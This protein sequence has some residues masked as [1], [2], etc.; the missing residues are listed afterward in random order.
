[1]STC[2]IDQKKFAYYARLRASPLLAHTVKET[3]IIAQGGVW[4]PPS[5]KLKSASDLPEFNNATA[6]SCLF[7]TYLANADY[8]VS[9][10]E[11]RRGEQLS[12]YLNNVC[13]IKA[14]NAVDSENTL[15]VAKYSI[16]R[17][18]EITRKS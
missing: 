3:Q 14:V 12:T 17:D 10:C 6:P 18:P 13:S 11:L 4:H 7:S 16:I 8:E 2:R 15:L 9:V 1:M 5:L